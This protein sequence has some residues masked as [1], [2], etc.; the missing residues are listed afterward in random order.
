MAAAGLAPAQ[1]DPR[2]LTPMLARELQSTDVTGF[3]LR[4]YAMRRVQPI[5]IPASA[6]EW[7]A[8]AQRIRRHLL[9]EVV[10]HG[11][12]KDWVNSPPRFENAGLVEGTEGYRATRLRYEVVPGFYSSAVL[13]EPLNP[14]GKVPAILNVHGH[15]GPIGKAVEFKQKRCINFAKQGMIAL[16]LE[17]MGYGELA[18]KENGHSY[19]G[20]LDL[21]G[22]NGVG[23]FYLAMRRGL[24]Y[25]D[26]HPN[27]DRSRLGVTGLSGGG[28]QTITLSALDERVA[29]SVP[30]AGFSALAAGIE[31]PEYVGND[32]EQNATDFRDGQD[33]SHLVAM[34][35]PRPTLLIYNAE[36]DCC[37]R[38]GIV[39]NG[40]FDDILPF[41]KLL[42]RDGALRYH[43]NSDPGTHNYQ[44]DNRV[45][46]YR[47]F[48]EQFRLP[49][50]DRELPVDREIKSQRELDAGLPK[51]NL[52]M[53]GV[54]RRLARTIADSAPQ[55]GRDELMRLVRYRPVTVQHAWALANTKNKGVESRSYLF[56]MSNGLCATGVWLKGMATP[57]GAP[58]TVVLMD[59]G[60]KSAAVEVSERVNR[61]EQVLAL[62]LLFFG[63]NSLPGRRVPEYTQLLASM[64]ERPVAM[65]A[66]QL[67]GIS[68]WLQRTGAAP[69]KRLQA[70]GMRSQT[71]ALL[72]AAL[73][74][75]AFSD[76]AIQ[77]GIPSL[78]RLL[79]APVPYEEAPDLFCLDLF[80]QFDLPRLANLA[81]PARITQAF[82][83][84]R[85]FA[86]SR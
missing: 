4:Q 7:T 44:L 30:V 51:D 11:W 36:D 62:D 1:S 68:A 50:I 75:A 6:Q 17:W 43:E 57:E 39:K 52:T 63:D 77:N 74:P 24:D 76:V 28:W 37:F 81:R 10:F 23:L 21:V 69:G 2:Q 47:F 14:Q 46:A 64:G 66:A 42:G 54:A 16:S 60:K 86:V 26:Q 80:K 79:E 12:P 73:D 59:E 13:Y 61:G 65:E 31:H 22:A 72:A 82:A 33:Y 5:R 19:A 34:R 29:V 53:L 9:D 35:A 27:A 78:G 18:G 83:V 8:E 25:L 70:T 45:Q 49:R 15:V 58:A 71:I 85:S 67:L 48:S 55:G 3:Q 38:S 56:E 32:I 84:S 20:H 41:F 40:V